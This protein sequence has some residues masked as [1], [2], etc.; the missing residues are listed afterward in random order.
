MI[1]RGPARAH[2]ISAFS[3][4]VDPL[5]HRGL[6]PAQGA[7]LSWKAVTG[8][9]NRLI[10]GRLRRAPWPPP[11]QDRACRSTRTTTHVNGATSFPLANANA[12]ARHG[13]LRIQPTLHRRMPPQVEQGRWA[14][15]TSPWPGLTIAATRTT[16]GSSRD[17]PGSPP[18][19]TRKRDLSTRHFRLGTILALAGALGPA[20]YAR[21]TLGGDAASVAVNQRHFSSTRR[22][23]RLPAGE[24]HDLSLP[25]GPVVHE[26]LSPSGVV[27]AVSWHGHGMPD[28]RELLGTY[29]SRMPGSRRRGGHHRMTLTGG[30]SRRRIHE[31]RPP[32]HGP[33]LGAV[34]RPCR[35]GRRSDGRK[36]AVTWAALV[37]ERS[38][39]PSSS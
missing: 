5:P 27:Y 35:R 7:F 11:T 25:S 21:A 28:L 1:V 37:F 23:R 14:A 16:V 9:S 4:R 30:D 17:G 20:R 19:G 22:V 12:G 18:L 38:S 3:Y 32:L 24:C 15:S 34:P 6:L 29:F 31:P 8:V 33:R 13:K 26:Y 36:R 10:F 39:F 2:R